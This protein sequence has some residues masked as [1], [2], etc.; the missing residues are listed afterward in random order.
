[1]ALR[2]TL[3]PVSHPADAPAS[4]PPQPLL[5]RWTRK[6]V[7]LHRA[8]LA[9]PP[10][11]ELLDLV[12]PSLGGA[13][14]AERVIFMELDRARG[15]ARY[16]WSPRGV[17]RDPGPSR[18]ELPTRWMSL[19]R[20]GALV[21]IPLEALP[22]AERVGTTLPAEGAVLI[23]P[24]EVGGETS[25]VLR[26]ESEAGRRAW[27]G[28]ELQ[29]ARDAA[30]ALTTAL[31]RQRHERA[32]RQQM[33]S[34][35]LLADRMVTIGALAAGVAHEINNPL[36]F[37]LGN[38]EFVREELPRA[39]ESR[40]LDAA[41]SLTG[42]VVEALE[43]AFRVE[44]IV[45]QLR[46]L[47]RSEDLEAAMPV[48]LRAVLETAVMMAGNQIRHRARLERTL[49]PVPMV[50]AQEARLGQ[51][52]INLLVNAAQAIPEGNAEANRIA[53]H[54][55]VAP[56][57]RVCVDVTDSGV[58]VAE[59]IR[60]RIFDAF[61]TTKPVGVGTGLGLSICQ[62]IMREVGGDILLLRSRPGETTF[63]VLLDAAP[64]CFSLASAPRSSALPPPPGARVLVVDD[65]AAVGR[66]VR[67]LLRGHQVDVVADGTHALGMLAAGRTY[68]VILC[69]LLMPEFDGAQLYEATRRVAPESA[70]R[71]VFLTGGAFTPR[72]REFLASVPNPCL[73]KPFDVRVL[74][75]LVDARAPMP[76]SPADGP[77]SPA[78][79]LP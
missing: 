63:R 23:L 29:F 42:V 16:V 5:D 66:A 1:M 26:V 38:L 75:E 48:D 25:A 53:V 37:T 39:L 14:R 8:L 4:E 67:R 3:K 31:E 52:F 54:T 2:R 51:V 73:A 28:A 40:D 50:W 77:H 27:S 20:A 57:G 58:G 61:F 22:D 30:R 44:R 79:P 35:L 59:D 72:A 76:D 7:D 65:E 12:A 78:D 43:G 10:T 46:K 68:D 71:F 74:R 70:G 18:E 47:S 19:L 21:E 36:T 6:L 13:L 56:T 69:D 33:Q 55:H 9:A 32:E 60:E 49:E 15:R 62:E 11:V 41:A 24:V 17:E 34:R 64:G 45:T